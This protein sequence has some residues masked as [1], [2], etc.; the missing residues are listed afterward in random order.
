MQYVNGKEVK[1]AKK[2]LGVLV[3]E[4]ITQFADVVKKVMEIKGMTRSEIC[5][6]SGILKETLYKVMDRS[7]RPRFTNVV[8]VAFG[9]GLQHEEFYW[10]LNQANYGLND[11]KPYDKMIKHIV[12]NGYE[13]R[14]VVG[15]GEVGE[16]DPWCV[17]YNRRVQLGLAV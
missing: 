8:N 5:E 15:M 10:F 13:P 4:N 16:D 11:Y 12:D 14:D 2:T 1:A 6:G 9:L 3:G 7:R 17:E